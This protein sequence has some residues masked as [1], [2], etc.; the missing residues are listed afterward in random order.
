MRRNSIRALIAS[1]LLLA[2]ACD[3]APGEDDAGGASPDAGDSP[4]DAATPPPRDGAVPLDDA[5]PPPEGVP[6]LVAIGKFGRITTSCDG[7]RTWPHDFSDD[8]SA[9]CEGIDCDHH[10]GSATGLTWGGG[11]FWASFGW[12]EPAMRVMRSADGVTWETM[13]DSADQHFAGLAWAGD[14]LVGGTTQPQWSTDGGMS[15]TGA[16]WP[17]WDV[18]EGEWPVGRQ[19]GF[20]PVGGGR[21]AVVAGAGD[22]SWGAIIVSR[23]GGLTYSAA[24]V[25]ADCRGYSRPPRFG[26]SAWVLPWAE[27]GVLCTS[28][29]GGETW[30]AARVADGEHLTNSIYTG[31]EH[32]VYAP[33]R[34]FRSPD[35]LTWTESASDTDVGVVGYDPSSASYVAVLRN[36]SYDAQRF[37]RSTD[38]GTWEELPAGA[39]VRGHPITHIAFGYG[40]TDGACAP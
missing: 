40:A 10:R 15:F 18:P 24:T 37:L 38:G 9:S 6:T 34:A 17:T 13:Y 20:A 7:G 22:G 23:D 16:E 28:V 27:T 12:G 39:H 8:D 31:S 21:I 19:I 29:D 1:S 25:D 14:R 30:T 11:Y 5:G 4:R 35:G 33:T 26:G 2:M 3:E 36:R 32:V